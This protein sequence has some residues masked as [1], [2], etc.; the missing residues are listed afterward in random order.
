MN[1]PASS[2]HLEVGNDAIIYTMPNGEV[3]Q[4]AIADLRIIGEFTNT[5]GPGADDYFF[6][7]LTREQS[8]E[9]SF[10]ASGRD[11][12]LGGLSARLGH[13][14]RTGLCHST[15]L[16]SRVLWPS[17][18]EGHPLFDL[19]PVKPTSFFGRLKQRISPRVVLHFTEEILAA[20]I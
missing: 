13:E 18:L 7:F 12:F 20:S 8:F 9:A 11:S 16:A 5:D 1:V 17:H 19:V 2:G 10:Y 3:W 14:L 15:S 4:I 6:V